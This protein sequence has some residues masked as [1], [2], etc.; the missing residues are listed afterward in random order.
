M[1]LAYIAGILAFILLLGHGMY[2]IDRKV[3]KIKNNE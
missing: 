2:A 3:R 1:V